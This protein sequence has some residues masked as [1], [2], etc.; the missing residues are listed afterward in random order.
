M[1]AH[2]DVEPEAADAILHVTKSLTDPI[3]HAM[4]QPGLQ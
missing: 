2:D 1:L 4:L 3:V